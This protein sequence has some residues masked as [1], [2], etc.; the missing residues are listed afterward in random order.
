MI[1]TNQN[2]VIVGMIGVSL[3]FFA[4]M[5]A[6]VDSSDT[7]VEYTEDPPKPV[8]LNERQICMIADP[9]PNDDLYSLESCKPADEFTAEDSLQLNVLVNYALNLINKDRTEN[10]LDEVVMGNNNAA[11]Q[12]ADNL[13]ETC[14]AKSHYGSIGMK[15]YMRYTLSGGNGFVRETVKGFSLPPDMISNGY[16]I[17]WDEDSVNKVLTHMHYQI[18]NDDADSE[19]FNL[20]NTLTPYNNKINI[21][22]AWN[23]NCFTYVQNFESDYINWNTYPSFDSENILTLSGTINVEDFDITDIQVDFDDP[24]QE[25]S[26]R[27]KKHRAEKYYYG[28]V[29][30]CML[31]PPESHGE[32]GNVKLLSWNVNSDGKVTTF[33]IKADFSRPIEINDEG[34]YTVFVSGE[35]SDGTRM[36]LS[37]ISIFLK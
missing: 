13:I 23:E 24:P 36:N 7:T 27:D 33:E 16:Y 21:G 34:V 18:L 2:Y 3:L 10:G 11:Q 14:N 8:P 30:G 31:P 5:F 9:E 17:H 35:T 19:F 28:D 4:I 26:I 22:I 29:A 6:Y 37:T 1:K 32:C 25:L 12:H 20:N 15:P